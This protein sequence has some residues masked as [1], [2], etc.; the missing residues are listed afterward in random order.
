MQV[1]LVQTFFATLRLGPSNKMLA[2]HW[3]TNSTGMFLTGCSEH[4]IWWCAHDW[5]HPKFCS[6]T[7]ENLSEVK[8][9]NRG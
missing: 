6:L 9:M 1:P 4:Q 5:N 2:V 8:R 7:Q 3:H